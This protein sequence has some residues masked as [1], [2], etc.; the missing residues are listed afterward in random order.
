MCSGRR[1]RR[2]GSFSWQS[3]KWLD[4]PSFFSQFYSN[5]ILSPERIPNPAT[6]E[7]FIIT[8]WQHFEITALNP[9]TGI[10]IRSTDQASHPVPFI[11]NPNSSRGN[12]LSRGT[13][14][15]KSTDGP[16]GR[17]DWI[18]IIVAWRVFMSKDPA[19]LSLMWNNVVL[20]CKLWEN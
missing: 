14:N 5:G 12:G 2:I 1:R 11:C 4:A 16:M 10:I 20:K 15:L 19:H 13:K 18:Q 6:W 17:P 7:F 3:G 9:E 8:R